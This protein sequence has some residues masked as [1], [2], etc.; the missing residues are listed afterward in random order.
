MLQK[1]HNGVAG[2]IVV[3]ALVGAAGGL[4]GTAVL[5]GSAEA[6]ILGGVG[7]AIALMIGAL[8]SAERAEV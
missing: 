2:R 8:M 7:G 4:V 6:G 3:S 5:L 1:S